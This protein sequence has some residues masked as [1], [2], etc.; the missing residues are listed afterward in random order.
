MHKYST[1]FWCPSALNSTAL[2]IVHCVQCVLLNRPHFSPRRCSSPMGRA[3]VLSNLPRLLT[4]PLKYTDNPWRSENF[5]NSLRRVKKNY[6]PKKIGLGLWPWLACSFKLPLLCWCIR[7]ADATSAHWGGL[8]D[9]RHWV[10]NSHPSAF[11]WCALW[12]VGKTCSHLGFLTIMKIKMLK[13]MICRRKMFGALLQA[14]WYPCGR[15]KWNFKILRVHWK[16]SAM[17]YCLTWCWR[18]RGRRDWCQASTLS[19]LPLQCT[20]HH[21]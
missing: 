4:D 3:A 16:C 9:P 20:M 13:F 18:R 2:C 21:C 7:N 19:S 17:L 14:W 15:K 6:S 5:H 8:T 12:E 10:K 1:L 11:I